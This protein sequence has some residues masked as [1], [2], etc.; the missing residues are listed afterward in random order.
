[1]K[2]FNSSGVVLLLLQLSALTVWFIIEQSV[3]YFLWESS[4]MKV[5]AVSYHYSRTLLSPPNE[6][7]KTVSIAVSI[8]FHFI[9]R[10]HSYLP[11]MK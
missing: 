2:F 1:M 11:Q 6:I 8:A 9:I 3:H 4:V 10:G 7:K 5:M